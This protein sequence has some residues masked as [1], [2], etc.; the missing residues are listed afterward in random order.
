MENICW[1]TYH[2]WVDTLVD[3]VVIIV[4]YICK[5]CMY[6][7]ENVDTFMGYCPK[8]GRDSVEIIE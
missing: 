4:K 3:K 8:C 6:K 7:I 2:Y 1:Y 5:S